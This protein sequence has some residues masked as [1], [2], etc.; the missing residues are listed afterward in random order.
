MI[1]LHRGFRFQRRFFF[2]FFF[3][4]GELF[5]VATACPQF[6][7]PFD[8]HEALFTHYQTDFPR[9]NLSVILAMSQF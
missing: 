5:E 7:I 8:S 3:F 9:T 1:R 4:F 6:R 2:F